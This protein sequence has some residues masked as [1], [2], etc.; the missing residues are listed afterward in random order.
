MNGLFLLLLMYI[1]TEAT[2]IS[3]NQSVGNRGVYTVTGTIQ[4]LV[5]DSS[6]QLSMESNHSGC[7]EELKEDCECKTTRQGLEYRGTVNHTFSGN[8][9]LPWIV[10][11]VADI[12]MN[13]CRN[14][15]SN[16][17]GVTHLSVRVSHEKRHMS[18]D[19]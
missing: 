19:I 9:C 17:P 2:N 3:E 16:V 4:P 14:N 13:Y 12:A 11:G 18:F 10:F 8:S 5:H 15:N 7:T 1:H 6:K